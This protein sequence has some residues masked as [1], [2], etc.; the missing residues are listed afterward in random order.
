MTDFKESANASIRGSI[1]SLFN[2]DDGKGKESKLE[3]G[4]GTVETPMTALG[5]SMVFLNTKEITLDSGYYPT[6]QPFLPKVLIQFPASVA[7]DGNS[8]NKPVYKSTDDILEIRPNNLLNFT[9][10]EI[11][12][13]VGSFTLTLYDASWH[14]V[15][16]KILNSKGLVRLKFGYEDNSSLDITTLINK[17]KANTLTPWYDCLITSYSIKFGLEGVTLFISGTATGYQ[18]NMVKVFNAFSGEKP[19][20]K[21]VEDLATEAGFN[22]QVIEPTKIIRTRESLEST[23]EGNKIF[24]QQGSTN[25]SFIVDNLIKFA[26]NESD[27]G[28]YK[29]FIKSTENGPELHFHTPYY[30]QITS[31]TTQEV[32]AFT[33]HKSGNSPVI[34]FDPLWD[35]ALVQIMGTGH[36]Y[37]AIID[38]NTKATIP[39]ST[40]MNSNPQSFDNKSGIVLMDPKNFSTS[41]NKIQTFN[42]EMVSC[43]F[44]DEQIVMLNTKISQRYMGAIEASLQVQGTT[45]FNLCDKIAVIV[46]VPQQDRKITRNFHWISGYY[47]ILGI[48]HSISAG[49]FVTT[50]NL[51]TDGRSNGLLTP[52][53]VVKGQQQGK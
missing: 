47:R 20:S 9:F 32:P 23:E 49:S 3:K 52:V 4:A 35:M 18:L 15:E 2:L 51:A 30:S 14:K 7:K 24:R 53:P 29:F 50:F 17:K 34:S 45:A 5:P 39:Y 48:K 19:I 6:S 36:T 1:G 13:G 12:N 21:I 16:D 33:L 11:L 31:S 37:S 44:P 8:V 28:N 22:K 27:N 40:D 43:T 26:N 38:A 42:R 25:L 46:Y 41:K 10:E